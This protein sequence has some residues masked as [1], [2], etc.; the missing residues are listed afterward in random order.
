MLEALAALCIAGLVSLGIRGWLY[1]RGKRVARQRF[2]RDR[3]YDIA[4]RVYAREWLNDDMLARLRV[5][6]AEVDDPRLFATLWK[7]LRAAEDEIGVKSDDPAARPDDDPERRE[8]ATL[9]HNY[10]MAVSYH[11]GMRGILFRATLARV[12]DPETVAHGAD[13]INGHIHQW[14]PVS[15]PVHAGT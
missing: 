14:H 7:A 5:M 9:F 13:R 11:R 15:T 1:V 10:L 2:Y 12:L 8:W 6:V 3:F 4:E